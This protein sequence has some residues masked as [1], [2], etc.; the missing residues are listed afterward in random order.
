MTKKILGFIISML[1]V[2]S[3]LSVP[4][5]PACAEIASETFGIDNG[6][7]WSIDDNGHFVLEPV[8]GSDGILHP[9]Y[10]SATSK[11]GS[12]PRA[13]ILWPWENYKD[14]IVTAE[15]K[16]EIQTYNNMTFAGMFE[17][18]SN[19]TEVDVSGLN[20]SRIQQLHYFFANCPKLK[21]IKGLDA[22]AE[23]VNQNNGEKVGT[24]NIKNIASMFRNCASL[25]EL[26]LSAWTSPGV[27]NNFQNMCNGCT[28]LKSFILNN[29][30]FITADASQ[31]QPAHHVNNGVF[32]GCR[33]LEKVDMS[34][35]TINANNENFH[36]L[37]E[38][39]AGLPALKEVKMENIDL[40]E[41]KDLS[42]MF[43]NC[44][45][46]E[47]LV[48]TPK[49]SL[50]AIENMDGFVANCSKLSYLDISGL[51]NSNA[52]ANHEL[53]LEDLDSLQTLIADNAM[54]WITKN[55]AN[56]P[57]YVKLENIIMIR[58]IDFIPDA[59]FDFTPKHEGYNYSAETIST[60]V[61]GI[62]RLVIHD[63]TP[64]ED[65]PQA[66]PDYQNPLYRGILA[67][68]TY[69]RTS[70]IDTSEME[71]P[72]TFYTID[73][74]DTNKPTI[75][76]KIGEEWKE[77]D[78][79]GKSEDTIGGYYLTKYND[80]SSNIRVFTD[81]LTNDMWKSG[82]DE[83]DSF[84]YTDESGEG[85]GGVPIRIT[86]PEAATSVNGNR[87]DVIITINKITFENMSRIPNTTE[88]TYTNYDENF[89][90]VG[91]DN[92]WGPS[93][94][95]PD[96]NKIPGGRT[97]SEPTR[98]Y[99][100]NADV[101][102]LRFWNQIVRK[103]VNMEDV[104]PA[105]L[106]S[107]GSG[108]YIDFTI[109][110]ADAEDGQSVLYWCDDL[111]MPENESWTM[112]PTNPDQDVRNA[113]KY[114]WGAEGIVLG[115]GNDLSSVTIDKKTYLKLHNFAD[116]TEKEAIESTGSIQ[117]TIDF[118][119]PDVANYL[120]GSKPDPE[121]RKTRFYVKGAATGTN[122][123][124]T[125]GISCETT[126]LKS[127]S[128]KR[129][130]I[131]DINL[132]LQSG[133]KLNTGTPGSNQFSFI[134]EPVSEEEI[135][136][137][138]IVDADTGDVVERVPN[139][140]PVAFPEPV[141]VRN[142]SGVVDFGTMTF[143]S[144]GLNFV[145]TGKKDPINNEFTVYM[146]SNNTK[147][148]INADN[149]PMTWTEEL[150]GT[151]EEPELIIDTIEYYEL[152]DLYYDSNGAI[153]KAYAF[154]ISE[155]KGT[156]SFV[157]EWD[158]TEYFVS[159][160]VRAPMNDED[161]E[162]GSSAEISLGTRK[163]GEDDITWG[164]PTVVYGKDTVS[165]SA[166]VTSGTFTNKVETR[167]ITV[168][169]TWND[170]NNRDGKRPKEVTVE[171][172]M[173][174]VST[175][176]TKDL[177]PNDSWTAEFK[178]LQKY[179]SD[180]PSR[181]IVYSVQEV[182]L[183]DSYKSKLEGSMEQGFSIENSYSPETVTVKGYKVWN[184][185]DNPEENRPDSITINLI[186]DSGKQTKRVTA[187]DDWKWEFKDLPKYENP[188]DGD[189]P[190]EIQY[191][192]DEERVEN[193]IIT[194]L[195]EN[196]GRIVNTWSEGNISIEVVK[197]WDDEND[198]DGFRPETLTVWLLKNGTR[199]GEHLTLSDD[200]K[201]VGIFTELP[202][203][204][205]DGNEIIYSVEEDVPNHYQSTLTGDMYN[206]FVFTNKHVPE[207]MTIEGHKIWD[208][209]NNAAGVRPESVII[210]L[211]ANGVL[212]KKTELTAADGWKGSFSGLPKYK[213]GERIDYT[214]HEEPVKNY[215]THTDGQVI[216]NVYSPDKTEIT[217]VKDWED[218]NDRDGM[219]PSEVK[220]HL[221]ADGVDKV[222]AVLNAANHWQWTFT[223]LDIYNE[224]G[225]E[226]DYDV[227]E[228]DIEFYNSYKTGGPDT[229]FVIE[230]VYSPK[231]VDIKGR[232]FW[233]DIPEGHA[234]PESITIRL[235][236]D[237]SEKA[238]KIVT[239]EDGW[240]WNFEN[241][242]MYVE[243]DSG[244][245][246]QYTITEDS[247]DDNR[248]DVDNYTQ[249]YDGY[250]V[251]NTYDENHTSFTV[252]LRWDD[253]NNKDGVRPSS[254]MVQVY[255][256]GEPYGE[257]V[258]LN[259]GNK[260]FWQFN[261]LDMYDKDG[262][263]LTW[264]VD[265]VKD[266][267]ITGVDDAGTYSYAVSGSKDR[268]FLIINTHTPVTVDI[269]VRKV[270]KDESAPEGTRPETIS[271]TL[272]ADGSAV[273]E[274]L[275]LSMDMAWS[276]VWEDL[277]KYRY[278]T[279]TEIVYSAAE[280]EVPENYK[281]TIEGNGS[282]GFTVTN[283]YTTKPEPKPEPEPDLPP[284]FF[285]DIELPQ[286][287]ISSRSGYPQSGKPASVEYKPMN[288]ELLVPGLNLSGNI[289]NVPLTDEGYPVQWLG[290]D[291]GLLE[292]SALPGQG[293]SVIA[294]HNTLNAEEYGPFAS[295]QMM[296]NGDRFFVR[297]ADGQLLIYEVYANAKIGA[298]DME[299]LR[300]LAG[301][302]SNSLTL[303]TCED[304]MIEGGYAS[305]RIVAA[306]QIGN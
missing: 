82:T 119:T 189:H 288:M 285:L 154:R 116:K 206:G 229:G 152:Y 31:W 159:I 84:T 277:P 283:T 222:T 117:E 292:G 193:Y 248:T 281:C 205:D 211:Q 132:N 124:W 105:F 123:K 194:D 7:R 183:P 278:G 214:W 93:S 225:D 37:E 107:K 163:K 126:I 5:K 62:I 226:I 233:K 99:L 35:I 120:V 101:G 243:H 236:A 240:S 23:S 221:L 127:T 113:V 46:L 85:W 174:N 209:N 52:S 140:A 70:P 153:C 168:T 38:L 19:L 219:R 58:D 112:H 64:D 14:Q 95:R 172:L 186:W 216:T 1:A 76:F 231:H 187:D 131:L 134:L 232:K 15:I 75:A 32:Y 173:D 176:K 244:Q 253:H 215:T 39:F 179:S 197:E 291:A 208:D 80:A 282:D 207:T 256:N 162:N 265:E 294:A 286:T 59:D 26:D 180:D 300:K 184:H 170:D 29:E 36:G 201:D 45:N 157:K 81:E 17:W 106:Y 235:H 196:T 250:N 89:A 44:S 191:Q 94:G 182:D 104:T 190:R 239:E 276:G 275:T 109:S 47:K 252:S 169:K 234:L 2:I 102:E 268:G 25:E 135:D 128:F 143:I 66:Q 227:Q 306:R 98:R 53:G 65:N 56:L 255:R 71:V 100:L 210:H 304:E 147:F 200:N 290:M 12:T 27:M 87:H 262:N 149:I 224:E 158:E 299:S 24:G 88:P 3:V 13:G 83:N 302:Y 156:E 223:D 293:M 280:T 51:D 261:G 161:L 178:D 296:E 63:D 90:P 301:S 188:T 144:P 91:I 195:D 230:N 6:L 108:T 270:W 148:F 228:E 136:G 303:M 192:V 18:C 69:V 259:S 266:E 54:V 167:D 103:D 40:R 287:G 48:F 115:A 165:A 237:G 284:F 198:N 305:R 118:D 164:T 55:S 86:Y 273:G 78:S 160:I 138:D 111:D 185:K 110:V 72:L 9:T 129:P 213:D 181:E 33:S 199:T 122:Y 114:G 125:T 42:D 257:P 251:T 297:S 246:V 10:G 298:Y 217:V 289:V 175:G 142:Q 21:T 247:L 74:M 271:V 137:I 77:W 8:N 204:D 177:D 220:V 171:L 30:D 50:Y 295:I 150:S 96:K 133:K 57:D 79:K 11:G 28:S 41:T 218:D 151:E 121:T 254:T 97:G 67:P 146:D 245:L 238:V 264:T 202:E 61:N 73:R 34:N 241:M 249:V 141:E 130:D 4:E 258:E 155:V 203:Y 145:D 274:P 260:W 267:V 68:G 212:I 60:N 92:P 279:V 272:T 242:P 263:R 20:V 166:V 22:W 269:P 49:E 16:G 139:Y 43:N